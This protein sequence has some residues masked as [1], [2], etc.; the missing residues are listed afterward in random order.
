M[1]QARI[2]PFGGM[3]LM[4]VLDMEPVPMLNLSRQLGRDKAQM[5]RAVQ[6]LEQKG[7]L[8]RQKSLDDGRVSLLSLTDEGHALVLGF[9][10]ILADVVAEVFGGLDDTERRKFSATLTK[11]LCA[12]APDGVSQRSASDC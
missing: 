5:T 4:M 3:I 2:G 11:V 1:D 12:F 7:L 9:Q 10:N 8:Q 6:T